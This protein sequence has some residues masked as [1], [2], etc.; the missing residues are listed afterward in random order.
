MK[1]LRGLTLLSV[2][3]ALFVAACDAGP[4]S[5]GQPTGIPGPSLTVD[6]RDPPDPVPLPSSPPVAGDVQL[7]GVKVCKYGTDAD[8]TYDIEDLVNDD[9]ATGGFSLTANTC[10]LLV[11]A[12]GGG[13]NV[14]VT[15]VVANLAGDEQFDK[16]DV[17]T[18]DEGD[19]VVLTTL[20]TPTATVTPH[21]TGGGFTGRAGAILE[22]YNSVI[23]TTGGEG[24]TP[25]F[26]KNRGLG[27]GWPAP[28]APGDSY[29]ATFGVT[30]SFG[31]TLLDAV[32]R[33]GGGENA[34]G[35]H[36]VAALLNA[37]S[38]N[39]EFD[40]TTGEV[41]A[42]VQAAYASGEFE[43]AKDELEPFNEQTAPGFCD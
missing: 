27:L 41:I 23:P 19:P 32:R 15:E 38:G 30:S 39:V 35:R 21:G 28:Y 4:S 2:G 6:L 12:D 31:G 16:L 5:T 9:D 43:D 17:T 1:A 3:A 24:C 20:N 8:F 10:V 14:T 34:L 18:L 42:L 26:W 11:L 40:L 22:F 36:A 13:A 25:G 7:E 37:A 29:D 33:G